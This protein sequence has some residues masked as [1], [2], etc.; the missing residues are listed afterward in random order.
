M[1]ATCPR[2]ASSSYHAEFHEDRHQKHTNPLNWRTSSSNISGYN[3]DFQE[4]R[5]TVG[6]WQGRDM[7]CVNE[8]G[9]AWQG[10]GMGSACFVSIILESQ[11]FQCGG[12]ILLLRVSSLFESTALSSVRIPLSTPTLVPTVRPQICVHIHPTHHS[13]AM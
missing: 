1:W 10:N 5:G 2:S 7:A 8:R 9:T 12:L 13:F 3:T 6:E 11:S 4:G